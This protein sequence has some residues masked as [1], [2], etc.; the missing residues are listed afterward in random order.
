MSTPVFRATIPTTGPNREKGWSIMNVAGATHATIEAAG[1]IASGS[2]KLGAAH[3]F[4]TTTK[5]EQLATQITSNKVQ[6]TCEVKVAAAMEF[7]IAPTGAQ[8]NVTDVIDAYVNFE[9]N[10]LT[11]KQFN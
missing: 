2:Q 11:K 7:V 3:K 1:F 8:K 9:F 5:I 10:P 6:G 4:S